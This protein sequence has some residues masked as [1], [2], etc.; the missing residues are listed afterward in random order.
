MLSCRFRMQ[1]LE[2]NQTPDVERLILVQLI[3]SCEKQDSIFQ[4]F[5]HL[6]LS[7]FLKVH[8]FRCFISQTGKFLKFAK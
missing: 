1:R 6:A 3:L 8:L 7:S 5:L 2:K 4:E